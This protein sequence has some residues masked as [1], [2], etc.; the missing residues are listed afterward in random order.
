M[1]A[2]PAV[3]VEPGTD[4]RAQTPWIHRGPGSVRA[5]LLS[6]S[7]SAGVLVAAIVVALLWANLSPASGT[8]LWTTGLSVRL[9]SHEVAMDLQE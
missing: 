8:G 4:D 2:D 9:G 6:E 1:S 3:A 5:L 7:G